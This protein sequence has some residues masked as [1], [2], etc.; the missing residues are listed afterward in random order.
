ML[1]IILESLFLGLGGGGLFFLIRMQYV[2]E[3]IPTL[4]KFYILLMG[5]LFIAMGSVSFFIRFISPYS[6]LIAMQQIIEIAII[7]TIILLIKSSLLHFH[8]LYKT[9]S[10]LQSEQQKD[11]IDFQKFKCIFNH[12][13]LGIQLFN[14]AGQ[15]IEVNAYCAQMLAYTQ[16]EMLQ[17]TQPLKQLI[18][19]Q[20]YQKHQ[21]FYQELSLQQR[22]YIH[23]LETR[24]LAKNGKSIAVKIDA[25]TLA[26]QNEAH[27]PPFILVTLQKIENRKHTE[28]I[29]SE[30]NHDLM[31]HIDNLPI[32]VIEW[33][34]EGKIAY[35][36]PKAQQLFG[37]NATEMLGKYWY[38]QLFFH[39]L[40]QIHFQNLLLRLLKGQQKNTSVLYRMHTKQ[41][42]LVACK[43]HFSMRFDAKKCPVSLL[44]FI[45]C[46]DDKMALQ[47][48]LYESE[49]KFKQLADH[50]NDIFYI[51]D[52]KDGRLV[53]INP[54]Y[55]AIWGGNIRDEHQLEWLDRVHP[56]DVSRVHVTFKKI[57]KNNSNQLF[58]QEYRVIHPNGGV[59]WLRDRGF[60]IHDK[61]GKVYRVAG[62]VED[63]TH[64]KQVEKALRYSK[65]ELQQRNAEVHALYEFSRA[66]GEKNTYIEAIELLFEHLFR[67]VPKLINGGILLIDENF[68]QWCVGSSVTID[69]LLYKSIQD[70]AIETLS[71]TQTLSLDPL[72]LTT[73]TLPV[74][75]RYTQKPF[76]ILKNQKYL[77]VQ[78]KNTTVGVIWLAAIDEDSLLPDDLRLVT[79]L[80][81]HL[82]HNL[83]RIKNILTQEKQHFKGLVQYIPTGIALFNQ[84]KQLILANPVAQKYLPMITQ[85]NIS[86]LHADP[87]CFNFDSY[88]NQ[89][90]YVLTLESIFLELRA[91]II[92]EGPYAGNHILI[93][94]DVSGR[95]QIAADLRK[96]KKL[97]S[98]RVAK[99]TEKLRSINEELEETNK[100]LE[101]A[102]D[103]LE[104][105]NQ[106]KNEFL[107]NMSHEL[108]TPLNAILGISDGL[109]EGAHGNLN[110]K[111]SQ[112][113]QHISDSGRHLLQL[114]TDILDL[115]KIE[116]G[117]ID[118][119]FDY[120][121]IE[122]F[123]K[124]CLFFIQTTAQKQKLTVTVAHCQQLKFVYAD[125]RHLKQ[126]IVNLLSNAVKFTPEGGKIHLTTQYNKKK[127]QLVFS[128][129]D[130]GIGIPEDLIP[131]LFK[132][133][134]QL[135]SK[136]ARKYPGAGLGLTLSHRLISLHGGQIDVKSK[137]NQ[138]SCFVITLPYQEDDPPTTF[139]RDNIEPNT[140]QY[141]SHYHSFTHPLILL[142]EDNPTNVEVVK[143]YLQHK[144]YSLVVARNGLDVFT[145][146]KTSKPNLILMDI[147][148]PHLDGLE[149]TELI[150]N[151][152]EYCHIPIIALTAF[153]MPGDKERCINAGMDDYI[154]KPVDFTILIEKIENHLNKEKT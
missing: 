130:T 10:V 23:C 18:H 34:I 64:Y 28:R 14:Q 101:S 19:P 13:P 120:C 11:N 77:L 132:P 96:E 92:N 65:K 27:S 100:K 133:F 144:G 136:L 71:K 91:D 3:K 45:E 98:Q 66:I 12:A 143:G 59:R 58:N 122:T 53:Y 73:H 30:L 76:Q 82:T 115:S 35:W 50:I 9:L 51:L 22:T 119:H 63:I 112:L 84:Q 128:I 25:V 41:Q 75:Q 52:L 44:S 104:R 72:S 61:E 67:L 49:E 70:Q 21:Q 37:W 116:A 123:C 93:I 83:Y 57:D 135:D 4:L 33:D 137:E 153:A 89:G 97:L 105:A 111:Q 62:I 8:L 151:N 54:A 46:V 108:R 118:L 5:I 146:L 88:I 29:L 149:A 36:S 1:D 7:I 109:C 107:A 154:S 117:K 68:A 48:A 32:G 95:E 69:A 124:S 79:T 20:E 6:F 126:V 56:E 127:K 150:R 152:E 139:N 102:N 114:I 106:L 38:D 81:N 145:H 80:I 74:P 55:Q 85:C 24:Y 94:Q 60:P 125:I 140:K 42:Q 147:Q 43:W 86:T 103:Q 113:L 148:M 129:S 142:A 110:T 40:D 131:E 78:E 39:K 99:R 141:P 90:I 47:Q 15:L 134:V 17:L 121:N 31:F 87:S 138:G 2:H 26:Q 16:Q